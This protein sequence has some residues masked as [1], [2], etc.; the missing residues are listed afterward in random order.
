MLSLESKKWLCCLTFVGLLSVHAF[1][2]AQDEAPD[3]WITYERGFSFKK[4][5]YLSFEEFRT[6]DPSVQQPFEERH[7]VLFVYNDSLQKMRPYK[8][9]HWG[10][11]SGPNIYVRWYTGYERLGAI[12]ELCLFSSI[13]QSGPSTGLSVSPGGVGVGVGT[14]GSNKPTPYL[15]DMLTGKVFLFNKKNFELV[16]ESRDPLLYEQYKK[17]KGKKKEK[18]FLFLTAYN[19]KH[20][21]HFPE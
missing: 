2:F 13:A 9:G 5:V 17:Y 1:V 12:G 16:L 19:E 15:I 20:P 14:G 10:Y 6:N 8:K 18:M 3:G 21:I 7:A 11:S 4:G